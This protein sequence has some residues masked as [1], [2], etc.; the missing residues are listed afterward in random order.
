VALSQL[1]GLDSLLSIV[2]MPKGVPVATMAV[3]GARNAGLMAVRVLGQGDAALTARLQAFQE[4][5]AADARAQ[6][7]AVSDAAAAAQAVTDG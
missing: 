5:I 4:Q 6:D 3:N 1:D 2:Q 7:S